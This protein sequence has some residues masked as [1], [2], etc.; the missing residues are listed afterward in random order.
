MRGEASDMRSCSFFDRN[1]T[2]GRYATLKDRSVLERDDGILS[3][4]ERKRKK[5]LLEF[6]EH[7]FECH[8]CLQ[9]LRECQVIRFAFERLGERRLLRTGLSSRQSYSRRWLT[10]AAVV[11]F[12]STVALSSLSRWLPDRMCITSCTRLETACRR[13]R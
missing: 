3:E 13:N 5:E 9:R 8:E 1:D 11:L 4:E 10:V 12:I 2:G 7:F 6:E